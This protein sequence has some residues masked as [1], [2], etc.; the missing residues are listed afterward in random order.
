MAREALLE[1]I[2][3]Q[4][5]LDLIVSITNPEN[6]TNLQSEADLRM[7]L[8]NVS[9]V[10]KVASTLMEQPLSRTT[11]DFAAKRKDIMANAAS[12]IG[13]ESIR[14]SLTSAPVFTPNVWSEE[15]KEAVITAARVAKSDG[16]WDARP[17]THPRNVAVLRGRRF[18]SRGPSNRRPPYPV[19]NQGRARSGVLNN[20]QTNEGGP[21]G[22]VHN[23]RSSG[24][25]G[26]RFRGYSQSPQVRRGVPS[27]R[28][29]PNQ[30]VPPVAANRSAE[31]SN[32]QT[33]RSSFRPSFQGRGSSTRG[34]AFHGAGG[35]A[36]SNF[37]Q[38][39]SRDR[40]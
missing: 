11:E 4:E 25:A 34:R 22:R 3:V 37:R 17:F 28:P 9:R 14:N 10:A 31:G 33:G 13:T 15:K 8:Y 7:H 18:L 40:I 12:S 24:F 27:Q 26:S 32:F 39:G 35:R 1:C 19:A 2:K 38:S 20:N 16:N 23:V 29:Q 5:T 6:L 36:P 21:N 30:R